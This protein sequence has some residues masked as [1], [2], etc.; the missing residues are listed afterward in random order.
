MTGDE[1][2]RFCGSCRKNVYNLSEMTRAEA[3][4][5]ILEKEGR[6]CVRFYQRSDGTVLTKD[7]PKGI[8]AVQK[9]AALVW[10]AVLGAVLSVAGCKE[11]FG[12][13]KKREPI[14]GDVPVKE[15][16]TMGKPTQGEPTMG[17]VAPMPEKK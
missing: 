17:I 14:M 12:E 6:L 7:C 10:A 13:C 16:P 5:L 4:A 15:N 2:A 8:R 9:R 1:K 3:E 11:C